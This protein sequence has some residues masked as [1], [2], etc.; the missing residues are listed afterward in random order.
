MSVL[1]QDKAGGLQVPLLDVGR[2]LAGDTAALRELAVQLRTAL[3]QVG[4]FLLAGHG[5]PQALIDRV[6][7]EAARFHALPLEAKM[8]LKMSSSNTGYVPLGG[9]ISRASTVARATKP[10]QNA[11]FFM[12]RERAANDSDVLAGKPHR[13]LNQWPAALPGY[14]ETLI[15]YFEVMEALAGRL[16]PLYAMALELPAGHFADYFSPAQITLRLS[17][18]PATPP[19]DGLYGLA[20]HTDAGFMTLL[21]AND[22]PG[23]AIRPEG[24]EWMDVPSLPGTFVVNSGDILRRWTNDRFLSTPHRVVNRS[25]AERYAIPFFFDP[26]TEAEIACLASCQSADNPPRHPPVTYG[27]YLTWFMNRNY[28]RTGEHD[29]IG[30]RP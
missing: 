28:H 4:F 18:Y 17:H 26:N 12:K 27:D 7:A 16:L 21:P 10:N 30:A 11:A 20:P 29:D 5:V 9:G 25:G 2:W 14:R 13:G 6:Y 22:V 1:A 24:Q 23:L 15:E 3:E 19:E 8:A